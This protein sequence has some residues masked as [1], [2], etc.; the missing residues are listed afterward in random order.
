MS[1]RT[2][3]PQQLPAISEAGRLS[4]AK[5][6]LLEKILSRDTAAIPPAVIPRRTASGPVQLSFAQERVWLHSQIAPDL[7][8]YN[9]SATIHRHGPL[10]IA[11]LERCL[12]EIIERHEAWR[13]TFHVANGQPVQIVHP[14]TAGFALP[15]VDLTR[16]PQTQ[17]EVEARRIFSDEARRLF[18]LEKGPLVRFLLAKFRDDEYRLFL[19][20][21]HIIFDGVSIFS[22]FLPELLALYDAFSKGKPSPLAELEI[23]YGDYAD[24][25]RQAQPSESLDE[26]LAY[27]RRQLQGNLPVLELPTDRSRPH[28]QTYRGAMHTF[29]LPTELG[30]ALRALGQQESVSLFMILV[31]SFAALLHRYSGQDD[32]LIGS[33]TAGRDS[34]Q[35]QNLLGLFLNTVVIC[36]DL[37]GRPSFRELLCRIREATL[38]AMQH[39]AAPFERLVQEFQPKRDRS[40]SPLF[41]VMLT[42][43]PQ[44]QLRDPNWQLK[45]LEAD[46]KTAKYDLYPNFDARPDGIW[47]RMTYNS[48]LFDA[49]TISRMG[50]HWQTLLNAAVTDPAR[51]VVELPLLTEAERGQILVEWNDTV[52]QFSQTMCVHQLIEA[53]VERTPNRVAVT[54]RGK[55]LTYRELNA[56]ANQLA[57]HLQALGVRPG[58]VV[59]IC[60][61][62]SNEMLIALLATLKT[63]S[64]YVPCDPSHPEG[65]LGFM[66]SDSQA[67][68]LVTCDNF[69]NRF[70]I[71]DGAIACLD[72]DH[73]AI[74]AHPAENLCVGIT[75][76]AVAY[77]IYTSGST[78]QPKGVQVEHR[79]LVNFLTS[80]KVNPGITEK[81]VLLAV[82]TVSFDIA[83]L[84]LY[85]PLTVGARIILASR[86]TAMD[87]WQLCEELK[88]SRV[89]MMQATPAT[90]RLLIVAG[91]KGE[92]KFKILCGGE[93]LTRKLANQLVD[94]AKRVWNLYGPTETTVWSTVQR[95]TRSDGPVRI[96]HPIGNTQVYV[97]DA[98]GELLP[99]GVPGELCIGGT[100]VARGYLNR[101]ELTAEKFIPNPFHNGERI[102]RTGDL[103]R[104]SPDGSLEY[105]GR[106]DHQMKIRGH[107]VEPGEIESVLLGCRGVRE[108]VVVAQG[109]TS[110]D[111]RLVAYWTAAHTPAPPASDLRNA[112]LKK[113]PVHM[114]PSAFVQLDSIPVTPSGKVDRKL[115][116]ARTGMESP[117]GTCFLA[118]RDETENRLAAIWK[119]T[120]SLPEIG[121]EDDFFE[122]G[123]HSLLVAKLSSRIE[124]EFGQR[125]T[126]AAI[127]EARTIARQ[128]DLLKS[129]R[130]TRHGIEI[131]PIKPSGSRQPFFCVSGGPKFL[132]LAER[133]GEEQPFLGLSLE[134][135]LAEYLHAPYSLEEIA[136]HMVRVIRTEQP[137]GPYFVGGFCLNGLIAYEIAQQLIGHGEQVGLVA[138]FEAANP[139]PSQGLAKKTLV[140]DIAGRLERKRLMSHISRILKPGEMD[141]ES[142]LRVRINDLRR[143]LRHLITHTW[144]DVQLHMLGG[145]LR[146]LN[147]IVYAAAKL[148]RPGLYQGRAAF[149]R[150]SQGVSDARGLPDGGWSELIPANFHIYEIPGD[151]LGILSEPGVDLLAE[152]LRDAIMRA[153]ESKAE[154][155]EVLSEAD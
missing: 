104:F 119:D 154:E 39:D 100:G 53:Q 18:D 45:T 17:R 43:E 41:Q 137:R 120:L 34:S 140:K 94:R 14:A 61:E 79:S 33:A 109:A 74:T 128:A 64:A 76:E 27:W 5:R 130:L 28:S 142:Y 138:L 23:Q 127:F 56:R 144:I 93:K 58:I 153:Q 92:Q 82:T 108:A 118:P 36:T 30:D 69:R 10:D 87:G 25:Q 40:R 111:V 125:L 146:K 77:V 2:N 147:Q 101:P 67:K 3:R 88:R 86:E 38:G 32:I 63:G 47:C 46:T 62:R 85:L 136:G 114:V 65:R 51:P 37:S 133:L 145:R 116:S 7:P 103:A 131:V 126:M 8:F 112:L 151:H 113:L 15:Q 48:A 52:R 90:W 96:G 71:F 44:V 24:W 73:R 155:M 57:R 107:R 31:A 84:E 12:A 20:L 6:E 148:Y 102:Y 60:L 70:S 123:G 80:M 95:L 89:T 19:T 124:K 49:A 81:D 21:H 110:A 132:P 59:G 11:I 72:S 150:C 83:A 115:L 152:V 26:H 4:A 121:I 29:V 122:L 91:W 13:T 78:G 135:E 97:L 50:A 68:V 105:L 54:C 75:P 129:A 66:L 99:A 98:R 22:V 16:I 35:I 55:S 1:D 143:D 134:P 139:V 117:M 141:L 42:L 9:E 106:T 149:F